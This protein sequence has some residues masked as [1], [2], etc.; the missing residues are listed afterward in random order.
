MFEL[1]DDEMDFFDQLVQRAVHTAVRTIGHSRLCDESDI[2]NEVRLR[3]IGTLENCSPY[4][5]QFIWDKT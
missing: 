3:M 5:R 1:S 4:G 2:D